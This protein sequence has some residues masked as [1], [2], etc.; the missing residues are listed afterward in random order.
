M[1]N[2]IAKD[3]KAPDLSGLLNGLLANPAALSMLSSLLGN[4]QNT[5]INTISAHTQ[6]VIDHVFHRVRL[7]KLT[8]IDT[9]IAKSKV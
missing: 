3:G 4:L 7:L 6:L 8:E 2:E 1:G 5:H 9:R